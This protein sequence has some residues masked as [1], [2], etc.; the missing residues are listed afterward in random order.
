MKGSA[1]NNGILRCTQD[2][3]LVLSRQKLVKST[4]YRRSHAFRKNLR[5]FPTVR[6][7]SA[8]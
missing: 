4:F 8:L 3:L 2:K 7:A 5:R 6:A 1:R